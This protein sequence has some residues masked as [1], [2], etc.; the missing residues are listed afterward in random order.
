M[1]ISSS[2]EVLKSAADMTARS[3]S[4]L[5]S[6]VELHRDAER[7]VH[8]RLRLAVAQRRVDQRDHLVELLLA[9]QLANRFADRGRIG[10]LA[11]EVGVPKVVR[12][13]RGIDRNRGDF[14]GLL[15]PAASALGELRAAAR[16]SLVLCRCG[17]RSFVGVIGDA[18]Q[19]ATAAAQATTAAAAEATTA[20][21]AATEATA[22]AALLAAAAA[23]ADAAA[24]W[25]PSSVRI[26]RQHEVGHRIDLHDQIRFSA[27]SGV[28]IISTSS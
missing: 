5:R 2:A 19:A 1:Y 12:A 14:L 27:S 7:F 8:P 26:N 17:S 4:R 18:E 11:A 3:I 10:L 16:L 13:F 22:T 9:H 23:A 21:T 28:V 20:L 15:L 25:P 24:C 6:A